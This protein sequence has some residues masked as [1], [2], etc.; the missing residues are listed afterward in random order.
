M[1]TKRTLFVSDLH[2]SDHTPELNQL[3]LNFL[4]TEAIDSDAL[5]ILG[6]FFEMWVGDDDSGD[7]I[8][9]IKQGL[10]ELSTSG[11]PIYFIHGNRDFLLGERFC[12]AVGMTKLTDPS[13]VTL[14]GQTVLLC[15]GDHL[16][17][18]DIRYQK[19]R[20]IYSNRFN[21]FLFLSLPKRLRQYLGNKARSRSIQINSSNKA[22]IGGINIQFALNELQKYN[23]QL[24]I[25]GHTH[26]PIIDTLSNQQ[27][28]GQ[29]VTLPSWDNKAGYLEVRPDIPL[30]IISL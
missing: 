10:S 8:D 16:C 4:K 21:Q 2:L 19:F 9:Q 3:F 20:R 1:T 7:Y 30:R 29:R 15:H 11:I 18:D 23:S 17:I 27:Q 25:H 28:Q 26:Q 22:Y 5:Y 13:I 14:Y 6:D 12:R 24:L